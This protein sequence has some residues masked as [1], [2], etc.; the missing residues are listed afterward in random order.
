MKAILD[1]TQFEFAAGNA[2]RPVL[3]Q[4]KE[5]PE[6][7]G[8]LGSCTMLALNNRFF[9]ACTRHQLSIEHGKEDRIESSASPL[10]VSHTNSGCLA[11]IPVEKCFFS[12][13]STEE[14]H[15]DI[16]L[17]ETSIARATEALE[18]CRFFPLSTFWTGPR[19]HSLAIGCPTESRSLEYEP[20][21]VVFITEA[22]TCNID[23]SFNSACKFVK[24]FEF[25]QFLDRNLDGISG[26]AVFSAIQT[27]TGIQ[28]I[29]DGVITRAANGSIYVVD[30]SFIYGL[31]LRS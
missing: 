22:I 23:Q 14:E 17:F 6:Y 5:L 18:L 7:P 13:S 11:N 9:I 24:R 25:Y 8:I 19:L 26:G 28:H 4:T 15:A 12:T 10:F 2:V 29:F 1:T 31:A 27:S 16:L 21:R 30:S 20:F 3:F